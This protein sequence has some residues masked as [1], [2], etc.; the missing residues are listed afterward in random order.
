MSKKI[1]KSNFYKNKKLFNLHD[2]DVKDALSGLRQFFAAESP[3]F[4]SK[5]LFVLKI[6]KFLS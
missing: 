2:L 3:Y 6:F 5:A 1:S 4:L